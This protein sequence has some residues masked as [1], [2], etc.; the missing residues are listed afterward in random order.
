MSIS[1]DPAF[2]VQSQLEFG[3]DGAL[4]NRGDYEAPQ[5][6]L[7]IRQWYAGL[8]MQGLAASQ[9]SFSTW[10]KLATAAWTL[11]DVMLA[12]ERGPQ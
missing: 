12:T 8:A 2:P 3:A 11:A 6:G 9:D 1:N 7:T 5:S 4:R 10:D